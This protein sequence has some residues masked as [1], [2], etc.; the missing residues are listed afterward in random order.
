M[1][2][3]GTLSAITAAIGLAKEL[4]DV[5]H[6]L[7]KADLKLKV[8]ELTSALAEAK[9]GLV[10]VADQLRAKDEHIIALRERLQFKA[11]KLIDRGS[12]RY[13]SDGGDPVGPPVCPV[14][15]A[16]GLFLKL[17]QDR[18]TNGYPYKCPNCKANYGHVSV[19]QKPTASQ[20]G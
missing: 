12:F 18:S 2:V 7:D 9:M 3:A 4:K 17:A 19:Y 15:E 20:A 16:K 6:Q 10:D 13:F 1:D 8:A 14:C 11:D 5:D